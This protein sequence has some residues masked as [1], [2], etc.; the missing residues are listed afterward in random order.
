VSHAALDW[1]IVDAS[2][3][4]RRQHPLWD[5]DYLLAPASLAG[6]EGEALLVTFADVAREHVALDLIVLA[7]PQPAF[8]RV[9]RRLGVGMRVHFVGGATREA[10]WAWLKPAS[11]ML[12]TGAG[13]IA[14]GLVMR[15]LACGCPV[16]GAG[17]H[18]VGPGLNAWLAARGAALTHGGSTCA[19]L[20]HLLDRPGEVDRAI[21][22]GRSASEAHHVAPLAARLVA[23]EPGRAA[24][25]LGVPGRQAA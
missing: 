15:A 17:D 18:G 10:E 20:M 1:A 25:G 11:A 22:R 6:E 16:L 9:A 21:E 3:L 8:E 12:V 23:A 5:G 24:P 19:A 4:T 2:A 13:P 7:D 14:A